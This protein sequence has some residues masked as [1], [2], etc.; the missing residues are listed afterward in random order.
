M[1]GDRLGGRRK[2]VVAEAKAAFY[3]WITDTG[4]V[5]SV[6]GFKARLT[7]CLDFQALRF[8]W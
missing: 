4:C 1:S 7:L 3:F 5:P 6:G 8:P 2:A